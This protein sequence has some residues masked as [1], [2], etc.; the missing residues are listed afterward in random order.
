VVGRAGIRRDQDDE[1]RLAGE[2]TRRLKLP[3]PD[4]AWIP[5]G[6]LE[7]YLL[8]ETH[9]TGSSKAH[10]FRSLGFTLANAEEF[11]RA[12]VR[13]GRSRDVT[14]EMP[15]RHGT[16]YVVEGELVGPRGE[17]G[18]VRTVWIVEMGE[19]GPRFVTAYP[20]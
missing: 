20:I 9:P 19:Q 4:K 8:S 12:L 17:R 18:R 7:E 1:C 6:K 11:G 10:Y 14:K 3:D 16:K 13:L 2:E 5:E 15:T